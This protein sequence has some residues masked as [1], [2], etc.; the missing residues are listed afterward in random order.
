MYLPQLGK[1]PQGSL[2]WLLKA[3]GE[4]L[5]C[6]DYQG[7]CVGLS[8]Y[9]RHA[10]LSLPSIGQRLFDREDLSIKFPMEISSIEKSFSKIQRKPLQRRKSFSQ[11]FNEE[12]PSV[13][14][15]TKKILQPI[16]QRRKSTSQFFN[17]GNP[18]GISPT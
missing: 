7:H 2:P 17:E 9:S 5:P 3:I 11:F 10:S 16:L 6:N 18:S 1:T 12:N 13:N 4:K 8:L 14:P 15:S